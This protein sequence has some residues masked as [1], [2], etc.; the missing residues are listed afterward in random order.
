MKSVLATGATGIVGWS[1]AIGVA[2]GPLDHLPSS[3]WSIY[4]S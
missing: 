4:R 1:I 3:A 2:G